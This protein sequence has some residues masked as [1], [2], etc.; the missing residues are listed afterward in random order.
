[1]QISEDRINALPV[2]GQ[3]ELEV[4]ETDNDLGSVA[5]SPKDNYTN[6]AP[7]AEDLEEEGDGDPSLHTGVQIP[8]STMDKEASI[9][10]AAMTNMF[11]GILFIK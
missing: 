6:V 7:S 3:V 11:T 9:V 10:N 4:I 8:V 2:D 5:Q 1:M